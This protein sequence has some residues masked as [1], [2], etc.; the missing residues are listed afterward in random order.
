[1]SDHAARVGACHLAPPTNEALLRGCANGDQTAWIELVAKYERLIFAIPMREGLSQDDA[2]D[3]T[4]D[5][6]AALLRSVSTIED[7]ERLGSWLMTVARRL[8]WHRRHIV[9]S[10]HPVDATPDDENPQDDLVNALWV[11]ESVR[12]LGEPCAEMITALF[13]EPN[14][15][16]YAQIAVRMGRPIGSLGSLRSRCLARLKAVLESGASR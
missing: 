8:T 3:I 11:Y 5:T 10:V 13:F 2:A 7:P 16:S 4:Q 9:R 1:M 15:P 14:E 6:F 12:S